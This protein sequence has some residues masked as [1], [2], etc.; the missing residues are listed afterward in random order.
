MGDVMPL[1]T[2]SNTVEELDYRASLTMSV[3]LL[4]NGSNYF[5]CLP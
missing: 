2:I 4:H 1:F 5:P 3:L